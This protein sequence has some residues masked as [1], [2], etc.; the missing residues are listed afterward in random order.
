VAERAG[1]SEAS[2][3]YHFKDKVG[4]VQ[5]IVQAGLEPVRAFG[6]TEFGGLADRPLVDGLIAATKAFE[7]FFDRVMPVF[8]AIQGDAGLR[9]QFGARMRAENMGAHRGVAGLAAYL[10][11][12]RERGRVAPDADVEAAALELI[13]ACYLR[14]FTRYML[15]KGDA[16][17]SGE[18]TAKALA[19]QLAP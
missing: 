10:A 17:P 8:A 2:V 3:Y 18:R 5:A 1:A 19:A 12:Q 14:A 9:K 11:D 4:L 16:L 6:A 7:R 15:G 13:G